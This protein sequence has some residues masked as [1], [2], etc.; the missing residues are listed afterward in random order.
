[1]LIGGDSG[2]I[3]RPIF[4]LC[5]L[6]H[7]STPKGDDEVDPAANGGG[8]YILWR[9]PI[10]PSPPVFHISP[11]IGEDR[12]KRPIRAVVPR[13]L[14]TVAAP[15]CACVAA[16][17]APPASD[18]DPFPAVDWLDWTTERVSLPLSLRP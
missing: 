15:S 11:G 10:R 17:Y 4:N 1:M 6:S 3:C 8:I 18:S 7:D 12:S 5:R 9:P 14:G 2:E 13:A 16:V